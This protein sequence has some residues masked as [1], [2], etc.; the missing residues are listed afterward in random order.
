MDAPAKQK[1]LTLTSWLAILSIVAFIAG[2]AFKIVPHYLDYMSLDKIILQ[3]EEE[4]QKSGARLA[5]VSDLKDYI[6][7]GMQVNGLRDIS[8]DQ[9]LK[10]ELN[11]D[12]FNVQLDYEQREPLVRTLSLVAHFKKT[13]Q[14][15]IP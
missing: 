3:A 4:S 13:Y 1:G 14:F 11:N 15:R 5:S 7:K 2:V 6:R 12:T 9:A 8:M 10:I